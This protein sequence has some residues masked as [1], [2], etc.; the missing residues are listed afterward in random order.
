[1]TV[2]TDKPALWRGKVLDHYN[3]SE[4]WES[5]RYDVTGDRFPEVAAG[6]PVVERT[7]EILDLDLVD[8]QIF[9]AGTIV[10][11]VEE[12][13]TL[14]IYWKAIYGT[15]F[16]G[17]RAGSVRHGTYRIRSVESEYLIPRRLG[18]RRVRIWNG[19]GYQRIDERRMFLRLH[20]TFPRRVRDLASQITAGLTTAEAKA[21]AIEAWLNANCRYS[22]EGLGSG[23]S[24]P[25]EHFLF[26][27]RQG[28][29][30]YFATAMALMLR[31]VDVPTRVVQG[32]APGTRVDDQYI[33]RLSDAHLWCEVFVDGRGWKTYDPSPGGDERLR[34]SETLGFWGRLRLKWQT[35]VL[36]YDGGARSRLGAWLKRQTQAAVYAAAALV[37]P[38]AAWFQRVLIAVIV[39]LVLR[40]FGWLRLPGLPSLRRGEK[41]EVGRVKSYF[42]QYLKEIARKGYTREP[43]TTPNDLTAA[44]QRDRVPVLEQA[45][46]VTE[47]FY[48]T[49]FG[50]QGLSGEGEAKLRDAVR[51][52]RAWARS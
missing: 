9:S 52:I 1:M 14:P 45:L 22:K 34:G 28:H 16:L 4:W 50:G 48:R 30:E 37:A 10:D 38:L 51:T 5:V 20:P 40:R 31:S 29:C 44:L 27:T 21:D 46:A 12:D 17:N 25:V 15:L 3:G 26:E 36:R 8:L 6:V 47:C 43:G 39:L 11:V 23:E 42:G 41:R 7:F 33:L 32:F 13:G 19:R 35:H 2:T 24:D 49:R 18:T